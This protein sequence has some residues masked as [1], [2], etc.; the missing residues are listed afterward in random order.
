[1]TLTKKKPHYP[2]ETANFSIGRDI[3]TFYLPGPEILDVL[4]EL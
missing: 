4:L 1:L 2:L 3:A